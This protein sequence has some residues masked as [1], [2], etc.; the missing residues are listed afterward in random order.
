MSTLFFRVC[1]CVCAHICKCWHGVYGNRSPVTGPHLLPYLGQWLSLLFLG[2]FLVHTIVYVQFSASVTSEILLLQ[3]QSWHRSTEDYWEESL[4][5]TW[6]QTFK[7]QSA[8]FQDK[9][10]KYWALSTSQEMFSRIRILELLTDWRLMSYNLSSN[11]LILSIRAIYMIRT[12][13]GDWP[14][15]LKNLIV[16]E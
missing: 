6:F 3:L 5:L 4:S 12:L 8:F 10:F 11:T 15:H 2:V 1:E 13:S 9:R 7:S 16:W 14:T